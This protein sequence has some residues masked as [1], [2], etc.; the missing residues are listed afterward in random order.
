MSIKYPRERSVFCLKGIASLV[1]CVEALTNS[2]SGSVSKDQQSWGLQPM[3]KSATFPSFLQ[4]CNW[5]ANISTLKMLTEEGRCR[6]R[7]G[8]GPQQQCSK[9]VNGLVMMSPLSRWRRRGGDAAG[10]RAGIPLQPMEDAAAHGMESHRSRLFLKE[11]WPMER[12]HVK[13]G[14]SVRRKERQRGAVTD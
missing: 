7:G 11:T 14:R 10:M 13:Q 4:C 8:S 12:R 2:F 6:R 3:G 9:D 1:I 5:E